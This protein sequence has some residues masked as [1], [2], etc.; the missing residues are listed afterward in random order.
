MDFDEEVGMERGEEQ[1]A[2]VS[3]I[4]T[5]AGKF[6]GRSRTEVEDAVCEEYSVFNAGPV[7]SL[8]PILVERAATKRLEGGLL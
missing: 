6:P 3:V 5:L 7:R 8:V 4:N 1:Q 2:L